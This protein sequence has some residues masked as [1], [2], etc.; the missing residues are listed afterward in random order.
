MVVDAHSGNAIHLFTDFFPYNSF[1][2]P[3]FVFISGYFCTVDASTK[4]PEY[5]WKR[6]RRLMLPFLG[7]SFMAIWAG[8]PV[9]VAQGNKLSFPGVK[10][11]LLALQSIAISGDFVLFTHPLWFV[12]TLFMTQ[13]VYAVAK[14]ILDKFK[15]W[16]D[17]LAVGIL[18]VLNILTVCIAQNGGVSGRNLL[19]LKC[20]FFFFF[21][22]FGLFYRKYLE[23]HL[24]KVNH[25]LVAVVLL[26]INMTRIML[27][28]EGAE[29]EF[30][31][32]SNLSGF[33]GK[34]YS[35][36]ISS[37]LGILF[38]LNIVDLLGECLYEN[39]MINYISNN[40]FWIMGTHVLLHNYLNCVLLFVHRNIT[41]L[42]G[43]DE[44]LFAKWAFYKWEYYP[45]FR[46][47]Y[48]VVGLVGA[49]IIKMGID[50]I[51]DKIKLSG[52]GRRNDIDISNRSVS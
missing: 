28:T 27:M 40:T 7:I 1:F 5:L 48:F 35:P 18:A 17:L 33:S 15:I 51:W 45:H 32:L 31:G 43:F 44:E 2:M 13:C 50:H 34:Y 14:K 25:L 20:C 21:Y 29:I 3:L 30:A 46:L 36:L 8:I 12:P 39:K 37:C 11:I 6:F 10:G 47:L 49:V 52:R 4:I 16:S 38:W 23:E 19:L 24:E 22:E 26:L 42:E 41:R 9:L